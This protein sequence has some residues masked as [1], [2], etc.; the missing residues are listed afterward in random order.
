MKRMEYNKEKK[1]RGERMNR[2]KQVLREMEKENLDFLLVWDP[3]AI[4]YLVGGWVHQG[5]R[6]TVLVLSQEGSFFVRN[7][8][9]PIAKEGVQDFP[10]S[11]GEDGCGL[12]ASHLHGKVGI[13]RFF[14]SVFLLELM[15]KG[16]NLSFVLGSPLLDKVRGIKDEEEIEWMKLSSAI[17]DKVMVRAAKEITPGMSEREGTELLRKIYKEEGADGFSFFPIV[18]FGKNSADP[19]HGSDDTVLQERDV[20]L[21]DIGGKKK[22]YCSDMTRT[23]FLGEPSEEEKKVYQIVNEAGLLAIEAIRVGVPLSKLDKIA[24]DHITK[25]G[26]GTYFTHRLGHFI[27]IR[28]HEAGEVSANS[29]LL[30][31][32]GMIFSIE[33]GIYLP[34]HFG[35]RIED[36][37]LV[38]KEGALVLNQAPRDWR[39]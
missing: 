4:F 12:L 13:D 5:E 21:L 19:H 30:C 24:R 32:E 18:A 38:T 14:P 33:P 36:L 17:N 39:I 35:V 25:A 27:G 22:N 3:A 9:F 10:F 29:P 31:E 37:V 7:R 15:E 6:L 8:L 23:Y 34:N 20:L 1:V 28:E 2:I 16:R 11:D 26:Y